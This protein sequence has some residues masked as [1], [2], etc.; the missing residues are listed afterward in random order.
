LRVAQGDSPEAKFL[1]LGRS[2]GHQVPI[3]AG[4]P[5]EQPRI[6]WL[7]FLRR[8]IAI[9]RLLGLETLVESVALF[10]QV[11]GKFR[12]TTRDEHAGKGDTRK[13]SERR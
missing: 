9:Q 5:G 2:V 10:Y 3:L 4:N 13:N 7:C 12:V 11:I 8:Q 6:V 1:P